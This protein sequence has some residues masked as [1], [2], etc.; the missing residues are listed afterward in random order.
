MAKQI[1]VTATKPA[2]SVIE[3]GVKDSVTGEWLR[4]GET[5]TVNVAALTVPQQT[6]V[7]GSRNILTAAAAAQSESLGRTTDVTVVTTD[8][9]TM[10]AVY[11]EQGRETEP[12]RP[13][14][15]RLVDLSTEDQVTLGTVKALFTTLATDDA[16]ARGLLP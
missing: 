3:Y 6:A 2:D 15:L 13:V 7:L 14:T 9:Q 4:H 12:P 10:Q 1:I 8:P 5:L 11:V 16:T